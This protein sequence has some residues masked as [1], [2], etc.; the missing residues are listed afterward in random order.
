MIV[1]LALSKGFCLRVTQFCL[2]L[3]LKLR[4]RNLNRND[5]GQ[6]LAHVFTGEV[7]VLLTQQFILAGVPVHQGGECSTEAFLMGAALVSVNSI[8]I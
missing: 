2:R 5:G 3:A 6:T 8:R 7:I 4:L 1:N